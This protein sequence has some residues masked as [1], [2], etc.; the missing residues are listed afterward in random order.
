M[1]SGTA[2]AVFLSGR[3]SNA[4][5]LWENLAEMDVRLVISSRKKSLGLLRARQ[6]GLP[7]MVLDTQPDWA[8]LTHE[9]RRRGV[10]RIFLLGFMKIL[11]VEFCEDWAGKIWNLHPSLLPDFPGAKAFEKSY[12]ANGSMGVSIHAVTSEMD[13]GPL[14][15]Q[16]KISDQAQKDFPEMDQAELKVSQTEQS[17]VREWSR[18]V[19]FE[20]EGRTW[21]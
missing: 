6:T 17:L 12:E 9:L 15:L 8:G 21:S 13:A 7:S 1:R 14:C 4:Q 10:G 18:R 20:T 2:W 3:G 16:K 5:A 19:Q 11:P